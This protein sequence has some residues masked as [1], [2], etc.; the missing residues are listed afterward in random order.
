MHESSGLAYN[1][2]GAL[3]SLVSVL[4]AAELYTRALEHVYYYIVICT[5][6]SFPVFNVAAIIMCPGPIVLTG[7]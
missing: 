3:H 5:L 7:T 4:I 2:D 1:I 6:A